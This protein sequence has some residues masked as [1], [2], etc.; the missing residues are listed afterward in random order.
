MGLSLAT[1]A[2]TIRSYN[3]DQP[4]GNFTIGE[5]KYDYRIE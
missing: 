3:I 2:N 4:L 1:I 5:K